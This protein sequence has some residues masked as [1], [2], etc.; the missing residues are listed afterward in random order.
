MY[1]V[2]SLVV[3]ADGDTPLTATQVSERCGGGTWTFVKSDGIYEITSYITKNST[4]TFTDRTDIFYQEGRIFGTLRVQSGWT[5]MP[6]FTINSF[7]NTIMDSNS[8]QVINWVGRAN[9]A[10]LAQDYTFAVAGDSIIFNNNLSNTG[11]Y[12]KSQDIIACIDIPVN[13]IP[14]SFG[15]VADS[16]NTWKRVE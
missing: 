3:I 16:N 1:P 7:C 4:F 11:S 14:A 6:L 10:F 15:P 2:D 5:S 13:V 12:T 8:A 9:G